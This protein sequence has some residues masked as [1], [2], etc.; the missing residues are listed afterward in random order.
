M[1]TYRALRDIRAGEELCKSSP[2]PHVTECWDVAKTLIGIS[3]GGHLTFVDAEAQAQDK[4]ETEDGDRVLHS[5]Q[6]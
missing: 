4:E 1:I 3:Y 2:H 6:L 5:I